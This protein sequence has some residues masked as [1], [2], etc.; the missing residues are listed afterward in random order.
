MWI[1]V[2]KYGTNLP[3]TSGTKAVVY[4]GSTAWMYFNKENKTWHPING[5]RKNL[6]QPWQT[7]DAYM[8]VPEYKPD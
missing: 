4:L 3:E 8:E 5:W 1:T 6:G 2:D 7:V